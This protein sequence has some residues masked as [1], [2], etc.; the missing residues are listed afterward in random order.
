MRLLD[1]YLLRE[2]LVP[3][4]YCLTGFLLFWIA[5][6]LFSEL[7]GMLEKHLLAWDIG[8]YYVFKTP[9]FL[10]LVLPVALLLGLLYTL[11][12]H[13]RNNEITAIRASGVSLWRLC[14]P[15]FTVGVLS[16]VGLF[17]LNEYVVPRASARAD[18]ILDRRI[19]HPVAA[20]ERDEIKGLDFYNSGDGRL[21]HAGTYNQRT[22]KMWNVLVQWH[23]T[24]GLIRMI[25]AESAV[26]TNGVWTFHDVQ[27]L[28]GRAQTNALPTLVAQTNLMTFPE[29]SETRGMIESSIKIT[30]LRNNPTKTHRANISISEIRDYLRLNP[31]MEPALRSWLFTKLYGRFAGP[32]ACLVVV[33]VAIPFG[34]GSNRRNVFVGV[35]ASIFFFFIYYV[36]QQLGF[37]FGEAGRVPAWVGAWLPDLV[38]GAVGL[39][40][41][42][43]VR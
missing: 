17:V 22:G 35:A 41:M 4:G 18:E 6:D 3:L 5:F 11:T 25:K 14:L 30:E 29:F 15:Y 8:E 31:R 28:M 36:L 32:C 34:T 20:G 21:W 2:F 43:R 40:M 7:H 38:F 37:A 10:I 27:E 23:V 26:R 42:V 9:E 33:L 16:T 24:G 12:N 39:G 19:Q 1:R 13:A